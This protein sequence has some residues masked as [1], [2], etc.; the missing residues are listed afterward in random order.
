LLL[1]TYNA[2][3]ELEP[4]GIFFQ[5]KATDTLRINS[6]RQAAAFRVELSDLRLWLSEDL[7]V[8]LVVYDA[9]TDLAYWLYIQ[10]YCESG[11]NVHVFK[12]R[13][14]ITVYFPLSQRLDPPA[15]REIARLKNERLLRLQ[16]KTS[17]HE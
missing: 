11:T 9:Q 6:K 2:K 1:F 15:M 7:P 12:I 14:T 4:G 5:V 10:G 17:P 13:G 8:I 3:G 16:G